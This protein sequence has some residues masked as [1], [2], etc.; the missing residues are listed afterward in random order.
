[1]PSLRRL[2]LVAAAGAACLCAAMPVVARTPAVLTATFHE[3]AGNPVALAPKGAA[4]CT[5][6]FTALSDD[7]R[8]PTIAGIADGRAVQSPED[9][10]AWMRA[11]I[12]GLA[13]RGIIPVFDTSAASVVIAPEPVVSDVAMPAAIGSDAAGN[14]RPVTAK[15]G[16]QMVWIRPIIESVSANVAVTID[17]SGADGRIVHQTYRGQSVNINWVGG[18]YELQDAIDEAFADALNKMSPDLRQLCP[19]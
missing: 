7:R 5:V 2:N 9:T 8:D 16:L 10:Q 6:V 18:A 12:G 4:A 17:A 15:F 3:D 1:M 11:V 13:R 19:A 14:A